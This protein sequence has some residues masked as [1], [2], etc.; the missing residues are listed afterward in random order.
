MSIV[1]ERYSVKFEEAVAQ[2]KNRGA[3]YQ[4]DASVKSMALV[5][6]KHKDIKLYWLVDATEDRIYSAKFFTYGGKVSLAI[7]ETLSNMVKGLTIPEAVSLFGSD[8]EGQLRDDPQVPSVPESKKSAF[9]AV[10]QLLRQ[11]E[12][13]YPEAKAV[14]LAS[15][16]VKEKFADNAPS[17]FA[18]LSMAEQAWLSLSEEEQILQLDL[19]LDEKVRPALNNDGGNVSVI[20]VI[21]GK[22][23]II[24]Y[25]GACGNCGSSMGSTLAFI[26]QALRR[27]VYNELLVVPDTYADLA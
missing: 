15:A 19:V 8:V 21:D 14:A 27:N 12:K 23:V 20:E 24:H 3:Y 26:E 6:A 18:A 7:G 17:S 10:E 13:E 11:V 2:P 22:K 1:E 16:T 4:E 9:D 25:Q 5:E